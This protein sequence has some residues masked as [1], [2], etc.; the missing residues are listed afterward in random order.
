LKHIFIIDAE[1][2]NSMAALEKRGAAK[3]VAPQSAQPDDIAEL[4]YT[5]G[6]TGNPKGCCSLMAI[7]PAIRTPV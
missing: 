6:T 1:G 4:I 7:L 5:S 2:E 3:P